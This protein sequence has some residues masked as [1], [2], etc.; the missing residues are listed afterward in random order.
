LTLLIERGNSALQA[1]QHE[2]ERSRVTDNLKKGLEQRP[3]REDLVQRMS[4][5]GNHLP[6]HLEGLFLEKILGLQNW[7]E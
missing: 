4:F 3:D 2:L 5:S 7:Q 1:A 6:S